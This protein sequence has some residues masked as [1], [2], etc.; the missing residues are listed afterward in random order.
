MS[1]IEQAVEAFDHHAHLLRRLLHRYTRSEVITS[2]AFASREET[3]TKQLRAIEIR[4]KHLAD[5]QLAGAV[6]LELERRAALADLAAL[7]GAIVGEFAGAARLQ[8][9]RRLDLRETRRN[10]RLAK[11]ARQGSARLSAGSRI[12]RQAL[13]SGRSHYPSPDDSMLAF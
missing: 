6:L 13:V 8:T 11:D 5:D 7:I 10:R 1:T 3:L 9:R 4:T 12:C 2:E